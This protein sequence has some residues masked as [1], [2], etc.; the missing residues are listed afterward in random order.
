MLWGKG[1]A[2]GSRRMPLRASWRRSRRRRRHPAPDADRRCTQSGWTGPRT[3]R[4]GQPDT[5]ALA[6]L[7]L[8]LARTAGRRW[9]RGAGVDLPA[10]A[11]SEQ[12]AAD[13]EARL[14]QGERDLLRRDP[15]GALELTEALIEIS[16][17]VLRARRRFRRRA[18]RHRSRGLTTGDDYGARDEPQRERPSSSSQSQGRTA[19]RTA[20]ARSAPTQGPSI[21]PHEPTA[22][23]LRSTRHLRVDFGAEADRESGS[24]VA[25]ARD[26]KPR[27][28][29]SRRPCRR[30]RRSP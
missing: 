21:S 14:G 19:G 9:P 26:G 3:A 24:T 30:A 17:S 2:S 23:R 4:T 8:E 7:L 12:L 16:R 22:G 20:A 15:S 29:A 27:R 6:A 5:E 18:R 13:A 28:S 1:R 11:R 25:C 10:A